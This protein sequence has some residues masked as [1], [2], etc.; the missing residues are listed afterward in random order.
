MEEYPAQSDNIE[1]GADGTI[2]AKSRGHVSEYGN[3]GSITVKERATG[4]IVFQKPGG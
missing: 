2:T 1:V 3:D 4:N